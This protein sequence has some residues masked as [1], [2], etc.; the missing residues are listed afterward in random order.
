MITMG[1]PYFVWINTNEIILS[2]CLLDAVCVTPPYDSREAAPVA[3]E[4][5]NCYVNECSPPTSF[6]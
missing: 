6:T 2:W 4:E 3:A 1:S 5:N